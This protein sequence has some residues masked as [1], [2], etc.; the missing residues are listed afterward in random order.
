MVEAVVEFDYVAQEP[1]ELSIR[2]GDIITN[3]RTQP[4]GWWEGSLRGK[5]GMFP[6]NFVKGCKQVRDFVTSDELQAG[7]GLCN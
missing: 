5:R 2:K 4:G 6:D 3:I 1:D 7:E